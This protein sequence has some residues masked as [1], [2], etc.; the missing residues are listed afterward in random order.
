MNLIGKIPP[1]LTKTRM[2]QVKCKC[3]VLPYP[4]D[5]KPDEHHASTYGYCLHLLERVL[6]ICPN[7]NLKFLFYFTKLMAITTNVL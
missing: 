4:A 2:T 3:P 5:M 6:L 1:A 7:Y